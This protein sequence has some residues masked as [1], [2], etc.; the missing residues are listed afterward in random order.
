MGQNGVTD[1]F[2][3][4]SLGHFSKRVPLATAATVRLLERAEENASKRQRR[5]QCHSVRVTLDYNWL[6][7]LFHPIGGIS[8]QRTSPLHISVMSGPH[9]E[10]ADMFK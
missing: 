3:G 10:R 1:A 9:E 8:L 4:L 7:D 6:L 5:Q 2:R